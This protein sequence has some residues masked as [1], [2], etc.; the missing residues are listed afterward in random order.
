MSSLRPRAA[1]R[2]ALVVMFLVL[3]LS[4]LLMRPL[5]AQEATPETTAEPTAEATPEELPPNVLLD[6]PGPGSYTI[7][8]QIDG[9]PRTSG[10]YIPTSYETTPGAFPLV[11]ALHPAGGTGYQM[12]GMSGWTELAEEENFIVIFPDGYNNVWNDGRLGDARI[13]DL[14]DAGFINAA[15]NFMSDKLN[16]DQTRIY[17]MGY[18]MGGMLSFRLACQM[19]DRL[20]A[21]ASVASTMPEYVLPYCSTGETM[22]VLIIQG[23]DDQV[24]PWAGLARQGMGYLSANASLDFWTTQNG[25]QTVSAI[26]PQPDLDPN[27]GSI[28]MLQTASDCTANADVALWGVFFG[29]HTYPGHVS[30]PVSLGSVNMDID[31]TR[32]VWDFFAAHPRAE[33]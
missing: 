30:G 15:I 1:A 10:V 13:A 25:C 26:Q 5:V 19:P 29:G 8:L 12:E 21:I 9:I 2:L 31:A 28:V 27:D 32:V 4:A 17:S 24:V 6:F 18:S 33:S 3:P 16:I 14:N 11:V 20:A 7:Q 23:T 22:P